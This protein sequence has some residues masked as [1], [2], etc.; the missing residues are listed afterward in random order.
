MKTILSRMALMAVMLFVS[1]SAAAEQ[2]TQEQLNKL[3]GNYYLNVPDMGVISVSV[4]ANGDFSLIAEGEHKGFNLLDDDE[5]VIT[6]NM[7]TF[8]D[9]YKFLLQDG[10]ATHILFMEGRLLVPREGSFEDGLEILPLIAGRYVYNDDYTDVITIDEKGDGLIMYDSEGMR[11]N[12]EKVLS[13]YKN[14]DVIMAIFIFEIFKTDDPESSTQTLPYVVNFILRDGE[15][16]GLDFAG[17]WYDLVEKI[18]VETGTDDIM[19]LVVT[20]GDKVFRVKADD[21]V[22]VEWKTRSELRK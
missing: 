8:F 4:A 20:Y 14:E 1:L 19:Y 16:A 15:V 10:V 22:K 11:F 6:D 17:E 9:D 5:A 13:W 18:D 2:I 12:V 3:V 7:I 21:T